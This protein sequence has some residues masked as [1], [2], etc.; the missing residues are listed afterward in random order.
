MVPSLF[1][2]R[3][4]D[5]LDFSQQI[6]S[7]IKSGIPLRRALMV[8]RD[9]TRNLGLKEALRRTIADIENGDKFSEAI[10]HHPTV[11][12]EYY[13]RLLRVGEATGGVAFTLEQ[14][15]DSLQKRKAVRD[16]VKRALTYPAISLVVAFVAAF[17]LVKFSLPALIGLLRDFG[18]DLPRITRLLI[19]VSDAVQGV[20]L[21]ALLVMGGLI[22]TVLIGSRTKLGQRAI[23]TVLLRVPVVGNI[24]MGS[25]MF[26]LTSTLVTMLDTGVAPIEALRLSGQS[27]NNSVLQ[28]KLEAVI[29]Q[30]VEGVRLGQAFSEQSAFP[31]LLSQAIVIG[32]TRGTI[33][34]TLRGL[35]NYYE[36]QTARSVSGAL[37]LIQPAIILLVAV[38]VGFVAI[39]VISGIYSTIGAVQ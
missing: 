38:V 13:V 4:Q 35:S 11:F 33:V 2:P 24:I 32:E 12:P 22:A 14:L 10:S 31:S 39:G 28:D 16:Q 37:E 20:S 17:V 1:Q 6:A 27:L 34:D 5:I 30:A 3:T 19:T 21:L 18:G 23:D 15:A 29:A 36:Q 25:N 26:L 9:Q 8:Q 7:L